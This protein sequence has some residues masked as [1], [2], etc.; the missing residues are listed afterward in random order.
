MRVV[1]GSHR[2]GQLAHADT[3]SGAN[4]LS[5]GQE[6]QVE[7]DEADAHDVVLQP[8]EMSL[9]HV[10]IVHG[11]EPNRAVW[12]RVGYAIRYIPTRVR[13]VGGRTFAIPARGTDR[14]NHFDV[15]PRP[16]ADQDEAARAAHRE[17]LERLSNVVMQG[18]EQ[19]SKVAGYTR[20]EAG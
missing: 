10:R 1:P 3:F 4:M 7:V 9:H 11:S 17:S 13:Q 6:V 14:F 2:K 8:G 16:A 20:P 5:R 12:P 19:E 18:A 15:P